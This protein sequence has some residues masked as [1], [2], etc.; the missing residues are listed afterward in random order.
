MTALP[1][2]VTL[3]RAYGGA[4]LAFLA[5]DFVWLNAIAPAFY[6]AN[7]GHL[8]AD[9]PNLVAAAVFYLLYI[10]GITGL[11]VVPSSTWRGAA[12]R[13]AFLGLVAYGTFDLTAQ[14]V[15]RD[16]PTLVT[17]ADLAWGMVLTGS[18]ATLSFKASGLGRR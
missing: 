15:F 18:V 12:A 13:G 14:A 8:M 11:A 10:A 7:I 9:K 2:P 5:I 16:W 1:P 3:A 17:V 4:F 6:A